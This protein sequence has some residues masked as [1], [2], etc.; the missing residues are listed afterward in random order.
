MTAAPG[1][2]WRRALDDALGTDG[3][4]PPAAGAAIMA[5]PLAALETALREAADATPDKA[6]PVLVALGDS[7]HGG[8]RRVAKR[9]L[10][11]LAQ[12]GIVP[13]ARPPARPVVERG[14]ERATRAWVSAIDGS[15][16]RAMWI[17]FDA[18]FGG[19]EL[20]SLIINDVAGILEAAGG[21]ITRKRL[22]AELAALRATQKL[23]W[24]ETDPTRARAL[25]AEAL[26]LHRALGTTPPAAFSRWHGRFD[27]DVPPPPVPPADVDA[28]L[29]A[30]GQE[31]LDVPEAIGWFLEPGDVQAE[32]LEL[33][34]T[35]ESRL[36]VSDEAKGERQDALITRAVERE[37]GMEA[38]VRW[39]RRLME[40]AT[41]F[42]A[43]ERA[44]LA[45]V[46]RAVGGALLQP[47]AD[48]ASQPFARGLARRA[49][50]VAGEVAT[51]RLPADT[52]TRKPAPPGA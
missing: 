23:P 10:Y 6:L 28:A 14:D 24:I 5:A 43:T 32:A 26:A 16:S 12:R 48:V 41:I 9:A 17:L 2:A 51:G 37:L 38:R 11:R 47:D 45:A 31:V 18:P 36:V 34:Q 35:E 7:A 25:V 20:C 3:P 19:L 13:P 21:E 49:L 39:A 46:A 27:V 4:L 52:A 50:E 33:L 22:D 15:G 42:E 29:A 40:M 1:E 44:P 8:V 30:R